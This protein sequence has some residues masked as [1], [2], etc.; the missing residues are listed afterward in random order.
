MKAKGAGDRTGTLKGTDHSERKEDEDDGTKRIS[1]SD[2]DL[3]TYLT[4]QLETPE[5]RQPREEFLC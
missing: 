5:Q 3:T 1:D 2:A 4:T